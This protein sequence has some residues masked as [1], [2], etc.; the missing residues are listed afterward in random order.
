MVPLG[1]LENLEMM[2]RLESPASLVS[3]DQLDLRELVDSQELLACPASRDTEVIQVLTVQRERPELLEPRVSLVLL[4]RMAPTDQWDLVVC[5]ARE[6]ALDLLDLLEQEEMTVCLVLL[7]PLAPWVPPELLASLAL[8]A[9]REKLALPVLV[10]LRVHR[11]PEESLVPQGHLD[12][13]AHLVTLVLTVFLDLK[14]Q[15][16]VPVLLALLVSLALVAPQGLRE[17]LD[18]LGPKEHLETLVSQGSRER[19]DPKENS[20]PLVSRGPSAQQEKRARE[21]PEVSLV[22]PDPSDLLEREDLPATADS[23]V[24]TV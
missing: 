23:L 14:V 18:L 2:V 3:V 10:D 24:R 13:P 17:P 6:A 7:V 20:D 8:L 16:V 22:L 9:P 15:P 19:L 5:L 12:L 4:E 1:L 21:A 11:D